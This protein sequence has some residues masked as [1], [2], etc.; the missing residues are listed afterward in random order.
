MLDSIS[1]ALL[2]AA[3]AQLKNLNSINPRALEGF[4]DAVRRARD[5]VDDQAED[6]ETKVAY[7][8]AAMDLHA[9]EGDLEFDEGADV[10]LGDDAGAYVQAWKWVSAED[11]HLC[12]EPGCHTALDGEGYDGRCGTCADKAAKAQIA[13]I[14]AEKSKS[15]RKSK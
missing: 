5:N 9:V 8:T 6:A 2:Q 10:S 3:E 14:K 4:G 11:A 7:L 1:F 12:C 15:K 13:K